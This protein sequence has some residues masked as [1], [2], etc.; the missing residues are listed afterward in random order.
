MGRSVGEGLWSGE[1]MGWKKA[2]PSNLQISV[3]E[4]VLA[5]VG[6]K[7]KG[8]EEKSFVFVFKDQSTQS[9]GT[10]TYCWHLVLYNVSKLIPTSFE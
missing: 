1:L 3:H 5:G 9:T 10:P 2:G 7:F 6:W 8:F 4:C